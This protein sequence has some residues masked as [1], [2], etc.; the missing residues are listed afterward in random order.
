MHE[1]RAGPHDDEAAHRGRDEHGSALNGSIEEAMKGADVFIGVS[2]GK[3]VEDA[4]ASMA[5][6]AM[7]FALANP[8]PEVDPEV[9]QAARQGGR[10]RS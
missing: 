9:A 7:V 6:D 1:G 3:V 4:V 2:A 10:D 5:E 8:D